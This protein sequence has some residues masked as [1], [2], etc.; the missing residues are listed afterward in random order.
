M[1]GSS[2]V[3]GS[4]QIQQASSSKESWGGG[5][6]AAEREGVEAETALEITEEGVKLAMERRADKLKGEKEGKFRRGNWGN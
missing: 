5:G 4:R 3:N 2:E 6:G 1:A